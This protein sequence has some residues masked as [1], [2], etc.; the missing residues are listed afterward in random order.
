MSSVLKIALSSIRNY[1]AA[2]KNNNMVFNALWIEY[3]RVRGWWN[4]RK[5]NDEEAIRKLY[6]DYSGR[7]PDLINPKRFSEKLQWLKL[8]DRNPLQPICADKHAVR[9]WLIERGYDRLLNTQVDVYEKISDIDF[10]TLPSKFVLKAAHSSGWNIICNDKG[11][12]SWFQVKLVLGGW[13][14]QN[15]FWNGREWP[16]KMMPHRIVCETY[17]EDVSGKLRDYKFYCFN[18]EPRFVQ[19][20]SGRGEKIHI[21]NFYDLE[22]KAMPFGK[23]LAP[24]KDAHVPAPKSLVQMI[25]IARDLSSEFIYVRVDFYEIDNKPIF[26]EMTFYPASGLPD[27]IPDKYDLVCGE[28]LSLPNSDPA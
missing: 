20:N 13:L 4:M 15:I 1:L 9:N 12:L 8:N 5:Y 28:M 11:D 17:L 24:V 18:G 14:R 27:F 6:F 2:L 19:A 26:G 3:L 23:D 7:Q 10:N 25:K 16:Y 22:W 21:Q